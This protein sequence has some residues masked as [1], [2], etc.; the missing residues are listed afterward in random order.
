[1][2]FSDKAHQARETEEK[3]NKYDY[4]K[5]KSFCKTKGI[6]DKIK[7][8]PT[9]WVI[10]ICICILT[11]TSDKGLICKIYKESILLNTKETNN[12]I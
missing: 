12:P 10:C 7:I 11:D 2:F 4:I 1:M 5:L 8:Q 9:A 6:I 3:I